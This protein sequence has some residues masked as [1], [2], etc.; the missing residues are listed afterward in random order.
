[1]KHVDQVLALWREAERVLEELPM[2]DPDRV[3]L[4]G[5]ATDLRTAYRMLIDGSD[6]SATR[7]AGTQATMDRAHAVLDAAQA[8]IDASSRRPSWH[9]PDT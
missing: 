3:R 4:V 6:L 1:M 5:I 7:L 2:T 8:R 9:T